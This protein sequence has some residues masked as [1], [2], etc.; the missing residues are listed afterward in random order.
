MCR[1]PGGDLSGPT[2]M[3]IKTYK[4]PSIVG[5]QSAQCVLNSLQKLPVQGIDIDHEKHTV[6]VGLLEESDD[7][8]VKAC[9]TECGFAP[10]E[11]LLEPH[12]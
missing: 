6:K 1:E 3:L 9:L 11:V 4:V 2:N 5:E 7:E 8:L 12:G 10:E